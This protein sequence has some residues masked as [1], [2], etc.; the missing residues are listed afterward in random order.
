MKDFLCSGKTN[1]DI[2]FDYAARYAG[3]MR[4]VFIHTDTPSTMRQVGCMTS[5]RNLVEVYGAG[6]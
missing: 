2:I 4:T 1:L 5:D 6:R 3:A